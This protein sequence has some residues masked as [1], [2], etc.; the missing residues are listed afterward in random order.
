MET[1]KST[2][3]T[4]QS[5]ISIDDV[6]FWYGNRQVLYNI[7]MVLKRQSITAYIGPS[8]CGKTTL[9]RL[10]NRMNDIIPSTRMTGTIRL[11]GENI[12]SRSI[13]VPQLRRRVGMV[14]ENP[15]PFP[16]SIYENVAYGPRIKGERNTE[17]LDAIV[18]QCLRRAVLWNDVQNHLKKSALNLS[19]GQKQRLCIAR[20]IAVAPEVLLMD[21]PCSSLDPIAT[22]SIEELML[23]LKTD[24]TIVMITHNMQQA[25]RVS[26]FTAFMLDGQLLEKGVT[27]DL[28]TTPKDRRTEDY[29]TGRA[30]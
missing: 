20:A 29:I 12:Y 2:K 16:K 30:G 6:S 21:E 4:T 19:A 1:K 10:M 15:N 28:F 23:D 8:G 22:A 18:E 13:D 17:V 24:Y 7:S 26:D 25:A 9:L 5:I 11:E 27:N 3:D 14:L